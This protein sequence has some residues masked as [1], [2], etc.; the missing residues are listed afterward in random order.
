MDSLLKRN[1]P[2]KRKTE[3]RMN[4]L[5]DKIRRRS[6]LNNFSERKVHRYHFLCKTGRDRRSVTVTTF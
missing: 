2:S 1:T 4:S 6:D 5:L 3:A